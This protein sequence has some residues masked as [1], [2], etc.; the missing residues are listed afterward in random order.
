VRTLVITKEKILN[1]KND[2]L[3]TLEDIHM[4]P[5]NSL[6]I[7]LPRDVI[8]HLE[9]TIMCTLEELDKIQKKDMFLHQQLDQS[10]K[11]KT[12]KSMRKIFN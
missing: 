2:V 10:G 8:N 5:K 1:L 6:Y 3:T 12:M 7:K 11:K 9:Y 4:A